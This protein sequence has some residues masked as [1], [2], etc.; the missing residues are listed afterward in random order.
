MP[1]EPD[2][3]I[4]PAAEMHLS[5]EQVGE[6]LKTFAS[7]RRRADRFILAALS[8]IPW[9]GGLLSAS[10]ALDAEKEQGL[11]NSLHREWLKEHKRR[12]GELASDLND[13]VHR[14][15]QLGPEAAVR[16]DQDSYLGLVRKGFAVW[17]RADT[18]EKREY[19]RRLLSN[20]AGTNIC[21]DDVVRLFLQ[22]ID[23][24]HELH[25]QVIRIVYK[26]P[27]CTRWDIGIGLYG[28]GLARENSAEA[29]LFKL[30]MSDL[31]IGRVVRQ[32]RDTTEAG[33]FLKRRSVPTPRGT[34][35]RV[36]KSAFDDGEANE[37]T[38][39]GKQFVHY[40]MSDIVP[41]VGAGA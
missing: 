38:E 25:F 33:E 36:M 12:L 26:Q 6:A 37:L 23:Y 35:S 4:S 16:L 31:N 19:V 5:E 8:S 24:Y 28:P 32:H 15:D 18:R 29:D 22:W 30:A 2:D 21:S 17:D 40:V 1:K 3:I 10:A 7:R 14:L 11:V 13:V 41:R 27:G 34:G 20:A 39:L 9:V